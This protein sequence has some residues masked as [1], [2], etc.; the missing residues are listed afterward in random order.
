ERELA[1]ATLDELSRLVPVDD[2]DRVTVAALTER[3]RLE[4]ESPDVVLEGRASVAL[5]VISAP[6][7]SL[8][9]IF[10]LMGKE[11][12]EQWHNIISRLDAVP[13]ALEQYAA[14]VTWSAE[15]G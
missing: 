1:V 5:D 12:E 7:Q 3:L 2:V 9:D 4:V 8:R 15:R 10:D 6:P 11:T 14:S 13:T